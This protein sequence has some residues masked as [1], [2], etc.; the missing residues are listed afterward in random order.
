MHPCHTRDEFRPRSSRSRL[1]HRPRR[2]RRTRAARYVLRRAQG[3]THTAVS[4]SSSL[5]QRVLRPLFASST[6]RGAE[7][8]FHFHLL[9]EVTQLLGQFVPLGTMLL[10]PHELGAGGE[11]VIWNGRASSVPY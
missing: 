10:Q 5:S 2:D 3:R 11:R 8:D 7:K 9:G 1:F 4:G 6:S